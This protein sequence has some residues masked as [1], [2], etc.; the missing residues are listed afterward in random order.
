MPKE[1]IDA[2]WL[3]PTWTMISSE[4]KVLGN[5][6]GALRYLS[7]E[8]ERVKKRRFLLRMESQVLHNPYALDYLGQ[9]IC[10]VW[11]SLLN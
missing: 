6:V 3:A 7:F 8:A 11:H 4:W 10:N 5:L 1:G 9:L 2:M